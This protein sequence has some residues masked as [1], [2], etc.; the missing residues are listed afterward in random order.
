MPDI[1][2]L[3]LSGL[4]IVSAIFALEAR[5]LIYGAVGL[6]FSLIGVAGLFILL[7]AE[8][9]AMFQVSVYVGAVVVLILFTIMLVRRESGRILEEEEPGRLGR[10]GI[11]VAGLVA[12]AVAGGVLVLVPA[13]LEAP[14]F[15]QVPLRELGRLLASSYAVAL[16]ILGLLVGATIVGGLT[17]VR[18]EREEK[19]SGAT[20]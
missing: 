14:E 18:V 15:Y 19:T 16:V 4:V 10:A 2:F 13:S 17:L 1:A 8:Y 9:L 12:L 20:Q 7:G 6:A 3:A 5:E 11:L